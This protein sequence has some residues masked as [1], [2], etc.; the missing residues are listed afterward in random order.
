[1]GEA[2]SATGGYAIERRD[3]RLRH[4]P[5]GD[6]GAVQQGKEGLKT[7]HGAALFAR[8]V[9]EP[10]IAA[11]TKRIAVAGQHDRANGVVIRILANG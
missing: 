5:H 1:L 11:A 9:H 8:R 7:F 4:F 10:D 3:Y 6:D 2:Q